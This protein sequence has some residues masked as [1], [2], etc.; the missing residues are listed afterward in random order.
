MY[1]AILI[2]AGLEPNQATVYGV[3]LKI[4]PST[5]RKIALNTPFKRPLTYNILEELQDKGL[6]A[7]KEDPGK[8]AIFEPVH[9]TKLNE[10]VE[11]HIQRDRQVQK[12]LE[13]IMGQL[14]SSY[15]LISGKPGVRFFEGLEGVKR[16]LE[17]SLTSKTEIYTYADIEAINK[18]I[19]DINKSYVARREKLDIKKR[20]IVIDT[21][22][23]RN[24]L[25]NYH[26]TVTE[27]KLI[28]SGDAP[29]FQTIMQIY[30]GKISYITLEPNKM[31]SVIVE[32][33]HIYEMH[34][35][36]FEFT[37]DKGQ[38]V[39]APDPITPTAFS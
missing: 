1:E 29:P 30:D 34:R 39:S 10:L 9:P 31:I 18:Y 27:T 32:D 8:V 4:G 16:V 36:L 37:W 20:G 26:K 14:V 2:Q 35:Y 22:F 13:T 24:Y 6:V 33:R 7:K 5:A 3:L 12:Q 28:K 23:A 15:N 21:P 19:A 11:Q 17:D 38:A 25:S